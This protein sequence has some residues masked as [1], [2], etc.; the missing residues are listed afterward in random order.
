M[1]GGTSTK[2]VL[3]FQKLVFTA[4]PTPKNTAC[5]HTKFKWKD[6]TM[7]VWIPDSFKTKKDKNCS[8]V[9]TMKK[10]HERS[11]SEFCEYQDQPLKCKLLHKG[12]PCDRKYSGALECRCEPAGPRK[13]TKKPDKKTTKKSDK[14]TT[15]KSDKK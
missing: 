10:G 3:S 11:C 14:K 1:G 5:D 15:K 4:K 7:A 9:I 6:D 13:T 8:A 2:K 12:N